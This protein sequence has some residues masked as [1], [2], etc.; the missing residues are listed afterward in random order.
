[1]FDFDDAADKAYRHFRKWVNEN[2]DL[3]SVIQF[4]SI[5]A[6]IGLPLLHDDTDDENGL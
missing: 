4:S 1:M 5:A 6:A 3:K 2:K